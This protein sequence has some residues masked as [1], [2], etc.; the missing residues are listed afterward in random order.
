MDIQN[1]QLLQQRQILTP[2]IALALEV[3]RMPILE[4]R[5]FL[6]RQMEENPCLEL[7]E[8]ANEEPAADENG[9]PEEPTPNF[10]DD[11]SSQRGRVDE[12]QDPDAGSDENERRFEQQFTIPVSF[13]ESLRLQLGC[14][15]LSDRDRRVGE[16]IIHHLDENGYLEVPLQELGV[17]AGMRVEQLE[18]VLRII[19]H[20]DPTGI[21]AR[22]LQEC[23]LIQLEHVEGAS[24][25]LA[26][27]HRILRDHFQLFVQHRLPA[28]ARATNT[29]AQQVDQAVKL[30]K[31]L[32]PKPGRAFGG[33][34]PPS[35]QPD[36]ILHHRERHYDVELNEQ[37][38]PRVTL[39]RAYRRMLQDA[40]TPSDA[41]EFLAKKFRAATWLIKAV[42][43]RNT[44]IL[45]VARCLI[46]LQREFLEQG[47]RALKPLTQAQVAGL[48]GRHPS[49]V[50]RA[51]TG[52]TIDTPYGVFQL[53]RFFASGVSQGDNNAANDISDARIKSELHQLIAAEDPQ[54]PLSDAALAQALAARQI[55]VARR[56][57]AKYRTSLKILPAHLRRRHC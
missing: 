45:A 15:H 36:L 33:T 22:D 49:T 26:L 48:I 16:M 20:L 29:S 17:E 14:Q 27:S 4:L 52:K 11:W 32:H 44:T 1:K 10:S 12:G 3:L 51:V 54:H 41:K 53:E 13:Y 35:I 18:A 43:E 30:I 8:S 46:S 5:I 47:P 28:L 40:S 56:T 24:P 31:Q 34:L 23:L 57:I 50:S 19:Q 7:G 42:D 25:C 2:N 55:T 37:E 38:V 9:K 21:G 39:S 6:E